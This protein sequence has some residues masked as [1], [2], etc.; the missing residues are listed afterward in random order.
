MQHGKL[1]CRT[2]RGF[3]AVLD[4]V[5]SPTNPH[6]SDLLTTPQRLPCSGQYI[7]QLSC[8]DLYS[9]H[10]VLKCE[11]RRQGAA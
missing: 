8:V 3:G 2:G 5:R 9:L 10:H 1:S 11:G 7:D 6:G 4:T